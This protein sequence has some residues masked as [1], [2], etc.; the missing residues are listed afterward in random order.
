MAEQTSTEQ[1]KDV[2]VVV[3]DDPAVCSSLEFA[4]GIEGFKVLTFASGAELLKQQQ[5]PTSGCV[6]IDY[7][8]PGMNGL[9]LA[10]ALRGRD[11]AL[12]IILI[13]THPS[14]SLRQSASAEGIEIVEKPLLGNSL[15]ESLRAAF[16]RGSGGPD[17]AQ[18]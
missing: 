18:R 15:S 8:L 7:Y 12:P 5:M 3:D 16:R 6:I 1:N 9:E 13:T 17:S 14:R 10:L 4:L 11:V 2:V